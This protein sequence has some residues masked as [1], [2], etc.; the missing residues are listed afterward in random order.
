MTSMDENRWPRPGPGMVAL[1]AVV[2]LIAGI[3]AGL[4][5]P[6]G[7]QQ[8]PG[9]GVSESRRDETTTT[10]VQGL[11]HSFYTVVLASLQ[12]SRDR[13]DAEARAAAFRSEGVE[14]VGV[15]DPRDYSSLSNN[16]AIYSGVFETQ[17][18]ATQHR[19][20]LRGRFPDLAG[21]YVK[22]VSNQS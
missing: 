18:E 7:S 13:S 8:G 10:Q 4:F 6:A 21:A 12:R 15:L 22:T 20:D 3:L 9:Q 19:D 5:N 1:F 11:P 17:R 16:W 2:G 14:D